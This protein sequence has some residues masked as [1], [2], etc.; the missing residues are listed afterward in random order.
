MACGG[1]GKAK[2]KIARAAHGAKQAAKAIVQ[3]DLAPKSTIEYRRAT[4]R[5]CEWARP[6][7]PPWSKRKCVC[8]VC[9]CVLALKTK[10][11]DEACPIGRWH[12]VKPEKA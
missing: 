12:A 1:C 6:C 3:L 5:V 11:S 10:L 7:P 2:K 8:N 4:C 9:D